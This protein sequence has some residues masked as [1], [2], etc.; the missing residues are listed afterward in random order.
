MAD[1]DQLAALGDVTF[2]LIVNFRDQ[3]AG[4]VKDWKTAAAASSSTLLATP[5]A[6]KT[7]IAFAGHFVQVFDENRALGLQARPRTCCARSRGGHRPAAHTSPARVRRFRSRV[8]P[9]QK[10]RG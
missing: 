6:L 10:P 7:V 1:Q 4:G 2:A 8:H 9:A 3:R 5:W